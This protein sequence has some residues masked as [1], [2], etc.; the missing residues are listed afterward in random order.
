MVKNKI[1][2]IVFVPL[3]II[4]IFFC[5]MASKVPDLS[6]EKITKISQTLTI[7]DNDN[8]V[9]AVLDGGQSRKNISIKNIPKHVIDALISTEDVRFYQ[10]NG[11]DIKRIFGAIVSD[12]ASGSLKEGASTITQQLIKN[13]HLTNEKTFLRKFNEALLALQLEKQY[14]KDQILE[15]YFNFVYFGRGAYGIQAASQAYFGIDATDL[16]VSQGAM[17]VGILKAPSKYA[18]HINMENAVLRRNVVLSQMK[19]YKYISEGE[20]EKY[21]NEKNEIIEKTEHKDYGYYTDYV[22]L[23][24]AELLNVSVDDL[25]AGGYNIYTSLDTY[26]QQN[27]Q[28]VYEDN[29]NFF[30]ENVQSASVIIDNNTG[31]ISALIGGRK[32]EGLRLFNRAIAKRQPGSTIKPILVFGPAFE[33]K[34]I[35]TAT[36]IDDY[37]KNYSGYK[38]TNFK[39]VYYGK[40]TVRQALSLSLNVPA[41]EILE[42]NGLEYSKNFAEKAGIIFDKEDNHL[43]LALGGM[44]YGTSPLEMAGA[45][46]MLARKGEYVEPY[47]V[48]KITDNNGKIL[49]EYKAKNEKVFS[50][51]TTF[52]ITDILCDVSKQENNGH[53]KL[54]NKIASKTGTVGYNEQGNSDAWSVGYVPSHT[55]SVW[56]GFDKT[57][58]KQYLPYT[59]TGSSYPT[60]IS[61]KIFEKIF[62]K[63]GYQSFEKPKGISKLKI[64]NY[65]LKNEGE[66]YLASNI[67]NDVIYEYFDVENAPVKYNSYWDKPILPEKITVQLNEIRQAEISFIPINNYTEYVVIRK[68]SLGENTIKILKGEKDKRII[69]VDENYVAGDCYIIQPRHSEIL[70][71]GNAYLG[72]KSIEFYIN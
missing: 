8:N 43:A 32:H 50:E 15:M 71:N 13:S 60:K 28:E 1:K 37:R 52:L 35:T 16:S 53:S 54:Q 9:F 38:P 65:S 64:D 17:L 34:S 72:Q 31:A 47:C 61:A 48:K 11:I 69:F 26:L 66:I 5:V 40:A 7:Y 23:E 46:S 6:V 39:N 51:N 70:L 3:L 67:Q 56:L 27:L 63:Y 59:V 57:T 24:S 2:Y 68:N 25:L 49:Y 36:L 58:E 20:F 44:K 4:V 30:D 19:K 21:K 14:D 29:S 55:V 22:F 18:P 33:N 42:K 45:Y 12:I 62:E 10:H 41:V